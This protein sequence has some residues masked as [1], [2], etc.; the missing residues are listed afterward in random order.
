MR[1]D[2]G[3]FSCLYFIFWIFVG[4]FVLLNSI[5]AILLDRFSDEQEDTN[6]EIEEE[7]EDELNRDATLSMMVNK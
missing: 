4:N 7:Y 6:A 3:P 5:L 2:A 1:S